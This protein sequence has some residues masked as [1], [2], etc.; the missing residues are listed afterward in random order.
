[1]VDKITAKQVRSLVNKTA[2]QTSSGPTG[3][4]LVVRYQPGTQ[5]TC[6]EVTQ[7]TCRLVHEGLGDN[8][9]ARFMGVGT[10]CSS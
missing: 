8:G 5:V 6:Y 7:E 3:A 1:M 4:C 2:L 10:K 9:H